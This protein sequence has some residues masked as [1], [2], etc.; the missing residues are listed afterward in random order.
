[1]SLLYSNVCWFN[2]SC[3]QSKRHLILKS[4][5]WWP[6]L[7][8]EVTLF[9]E[10]TTHPINVPMILRLNLMKSH[11]HSNEY[12]GLI[13]FH[14]KSFQW[15]SNK[16]THDIPISHWTAPFNGQLKPTKINPI[17]YIVDQIRITI[18]MAIYV[19]IFINPY[20]N[21]PMVSSI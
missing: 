6:V 1:M 11:S 17:Q 16:Y 7:Q 19:R 10:V 12:P 9:G 13:S 15:Y 18:H 4:A 21:F 3:F 20:I 2:P 8:S 14:R 5:V